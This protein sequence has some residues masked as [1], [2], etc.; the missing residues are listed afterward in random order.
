LVQIAD[1][2][3]SATPKKEPEARAKN[4]RARTQV[5][6][7]TVV[8]LEISAMRKKLRRL[9]IK[10]RYRLARWLEAKA[11]QIEDKTMDMEVDDLMVGFK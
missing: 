6:E 4:H 9:H 11:R 1:G 8:P 3:Y 2:K 7:S 10:A 5:G